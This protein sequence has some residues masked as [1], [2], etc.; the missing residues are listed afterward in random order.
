M[1]GLI[2]AGVVA[3]V[4][5]MSCV[6]A[7]SNAP[8]ASEPPVSMSASATPAASPAVTASTSAAS[9]APAPADLGLVDAH[10]HYS[11]DAWAAYPPEAALAILHRAG[12]R[13]AFVSSTPDEGT[14]RLYDRDPALV[15]PVLRPYRTRD[16]IGRWVSDPTV[17]T[18]VESGFRRGVHRGIGEF[19]LAAGQAASPVVRRIVALA[20]RED[21]FLHAH[22]DARAVAELLSVDPEARVLWA[23]AG[24]SE[25]ATT[26]GAMLDRFPNLT[27]ELALRSDVAPGG[28]LAPEWRELFVRH[29]DRFMLGTDTW[30]PGRWEAVVDT[31]VQT[32]GW[33]AQ[34][35][36]D[37]A[38]R[39]A[40]G[41][42]E[43]LVGAP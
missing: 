38:E 17:A 25:T 5:L 33:L 13:R 23:H 6:P 2:A 29:A 10:I 32:R 35:P 9:P 15:V 14:M 39:I 8:T 1:K 42:A 41:N 24:M 3:F 22:A 36:P 18:Y 20:V 21:V 40:R 12:I 30:V 34:L 37:V 27:V 43:R 4:A 19:H 16:D 26:V 7:T 31:A 11:E 28:Q